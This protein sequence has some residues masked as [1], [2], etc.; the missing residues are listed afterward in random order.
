ML[1]PASTG[2]KSKHSPQAEQEEGKA[3]VYLLNKI[4]MINKSH[5]YISLEEY[6]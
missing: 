5:V 4:P 1:I 3:D 6:F 2:T